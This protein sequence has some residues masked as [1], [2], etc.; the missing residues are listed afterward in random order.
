MVLKIPSLP[1]PSK[2]FSKGLNN[3]SMKSMWILRND[4]VQVFRAAKKLFVGIN[5]LFA[6]ND[7]HMI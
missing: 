5:D 7:N 1:P 2:F 3:T 6:A 4:W